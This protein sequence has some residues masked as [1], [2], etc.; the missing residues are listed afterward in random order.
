MLIL[1]ERLLFACFLHPLILL[2]LRACVCVC[3]FEDKTV[4]IYNK[5][6]HR[7][8][9]LCRL[10]SADSAISTHAHERGGALQ[11]RYASV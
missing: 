10:I 9:G 2:Y 7:P 8:T 1:S 3:V 11:L 5:E 6:R 4:Y